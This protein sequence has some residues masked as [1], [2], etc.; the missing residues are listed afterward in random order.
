MKIASSE[1]GAASFVFPRLLGLLGSLS[2]LR[3]WYF[4]FE[5]RSSLG[6]WSSYFESRLSNHQPDVR[7]ARPMFAIVRVDL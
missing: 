6:F 2:S 1:R 5:S 4:S 7:Q 3:F